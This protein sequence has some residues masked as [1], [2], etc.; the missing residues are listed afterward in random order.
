MTFPLAQF[1]YEQRTLTSITVGPPKDQKAR[2]SLRFQCC[3]TSKPPISNGARMNRGS[4]N[5][6]RIL[7]NALLT[8]GWLMPKLLAARL[9]LS[10]LCRVP[11]SV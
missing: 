10:S 4:L 3:F 11:Q 5:A 2:R 6:T 8:A 9:T 7:R 1:A